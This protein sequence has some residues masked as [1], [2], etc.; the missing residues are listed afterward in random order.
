MLSVEMLTTHRTM[1]TLNLCAMSLAVLI[2]GD[3]SVLWLGSGVLGAVLS[4]GLRSPGKACAYSMLSAHRISGA[5]EPR[6]STC[7]RK[8]SLPVPLKDPTTELRI[9]CHF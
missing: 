8:G 5:V 4:L 9:W 7:F 6:E 1:G 3:A 2:M